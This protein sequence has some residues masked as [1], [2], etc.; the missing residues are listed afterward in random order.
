MFLGQGVFDEK[1]TYKQTKK[2]HSH[3]HSQHREKPKTDNHSAATLWNLNIITLQ[4]SDSFGLYE[5]THSCVF[6]PVKTCQRWSGYIAVFTQLVR[7][8]IICLVVQEFVYGRHR[9]WVNLRQ[10][11]TQFIKDLIWQVPKFLMLLIQITEVLG[12]TTK[13]F[14]SKAV[15][16]HR[17]VYMKVCQR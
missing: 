16:K 7:G 15:G 3:P 5:H 8:I 13:C 11:N 14:K 10:T 6:W 2:I 9:K 17:I 4:S 12:K 1:K